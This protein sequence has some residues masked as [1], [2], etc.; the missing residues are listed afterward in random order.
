MVSLGAR[1]GVEPVDRDGLVLIDR[2]GMCMAGQRL[3]DTRHAHGSA[4]AA[5][6]DPNSCAL[7]ETER[8]LGETVLRQ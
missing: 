2:T 3:I 1:R 5:G 8:I 7:L 6:R 4:R